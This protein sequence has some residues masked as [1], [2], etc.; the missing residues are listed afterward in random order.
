[1]PISIFHIVASQPD[2]LFR[3]LLNR[4]H[5]YSD[6]LIGLIKLLVNYLYLSLSHIDRPSVRNNSEI[7]CIETSVYARKFCV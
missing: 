4:T 5:F 7:S 3:C 1:M 2:H 6:K